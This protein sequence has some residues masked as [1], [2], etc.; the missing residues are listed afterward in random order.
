MENIVTPVN[1][2]AFERLLKESGYQPEKTKFL[3][4]GFT[5]GFN[6]QFQGDRKV[7]HEANNLKIR[8]GSHLE[9]WNKIMKEVKGKRYAGPFLK[10]PFE[11]YYQS[12]VGLVPKDGGKKTRLIFHL[13]YPRGGGQSV[14]AGMNRESCSVHYPD[15]NEA[16]K[17]CLDVMSNSN[18][19]CY[20]GKSDM[21]MAFRNIPLKIKD[22]SLLV[23]KARHP[24]TGIWYFFVDK[25]LPFG[26]SI[27]CA[28][29]QEFSNSISFLVTHR[30]KRPNVN[31]LDDFLF[32]ALL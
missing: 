22:F 31:Y 2:E 20:V 11:Y 1:V 23:L 29:F 15:F 32:A 19:P 28:I 3:V 7:I 14:N 10:P 4:D 27:S 9:L 8:C 13:S 24:I 6:L 17:L 21:S 18:S 16:I 12:P 30:T 5:R 25:C 26:A